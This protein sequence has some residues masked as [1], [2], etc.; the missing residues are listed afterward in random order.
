[1]RAR[2]SLLTSPRAS[3]LK[4]MVWEDTKFTM[5]SKM[6]RS[7]GLTCGSISFAFTY[8]SSEAK[9]S[10]TSKPSRRSIHA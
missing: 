10:A 5:A 3:E 6:M 7:R 2:S 9:I 4:L 1:M 8:S